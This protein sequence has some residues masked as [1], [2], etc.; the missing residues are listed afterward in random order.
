MLAVVALAAL[1]PGL[2]A[3]HGPLHLEQV[4]AAGIALV[5]FLSGIGLSTANLKAGARNWK[6]HLLVQS[7][8]YLLFPALGIAVMLAASDH[9]P[10]ALLQGF[11]FLCALSSTVSTSIAMTRIAR[12]N[13]AGAVFNASLSS[14]LGMLLTPL[15]VSLWLHAAQGPRSMT[16]ELLAIAE[17]L[18]LPFLAGQLLRPA[19]GGWI[20]RHQAVFGK[21]DRLVILLI[22]YNSFCD[23]SRA[24]LWRDYGVATLLQVLALTGGLLALV[25]SL[26]TFFARRL[27][28]SKEDEITAVFCGSKKSLAMGIPMAKLLFG[29]GAID[30]AAFG[31][32]VLP[33]MFYHQWQLLAGSVLANRYARRKA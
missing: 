31:L 29:A 7:C 28:F 1:D 26:T 19:L 12:G 30:A 21:A 25:L 13:I 2:G 14:L 32:L 5:F 27:H 6:L 9:L 17:Q 8:T 10:R 4:S 18:L 33:L 22:V 16:D 24:G 23:A 11:F 15:W 3:S 20:A